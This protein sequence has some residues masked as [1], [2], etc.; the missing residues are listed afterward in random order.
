[1][2]L[3]GREKFEVRCTEAVLSF[4]ELLLHIPCFG[5]HRGIVKERGLC[6]GDGRRAKLDV[7]LPKA[8]GGKRPLFVYI[9]GGGY[10]SGIRSNRR[11]YCY[12]WVD[13]GFVAANIDYD[14]ALAAEH[15][16]HIRQI[17]KGIEFVL[18]RAEEYG[19]DRDRVVV[20]GDSAG[21]YFAAMVSAISV[22]R[23]L[24]GLLGIDF[25]YKDTF[26]VSACVTLSGIFDPVRAVDTRYPQMGLFTSVLLGKS[27][28]E[29][30]AM[31]GDEA[32][33]VTYAA[34]ARLTAEYPP[35]FVVASK[36]DRLK[37]E[38]DDFTDELE[39]AGARHGYFLC[40][41]I[42]GV[43]AGA[44]ACGLSRSGRECLAEAKK[45]VQE[46]LVRSEAADG[47]K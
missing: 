16:G 17:F 8:E 19:I 12:N 18:D 1:M 44:L 7:Y 27:R 37:K 4:S 28:R 25:D 26:R 41:G 24:Y 34:D 35:V 10:L 23:D 40:T 9:H 36:Y 33:R 5:V 11:F 32:L 46:A 15:P 43:H 42:N 38:S 21:G 6:Y 29:V 14:Y 22:R 13:E 20:A 47:E 45:F 3:T 2:G 31:K 30:A 39:A